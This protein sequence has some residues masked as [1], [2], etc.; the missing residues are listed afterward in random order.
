VVANPTVIN[1]C[2]SWARPVWTITGPATE[3]TLENR[4]TGEVLHWEGNVAEGQTLV[5]DTRRDR[6]TATIL[7]TTNAYAGLGMSRLWPL[8]PGTNELSLQLAEAGPAT[9]VALEFE[10]TYLSC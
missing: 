5:I 6:K 10:R 8:A 4:T 9:T 2:D 1:P 7:P 3:V